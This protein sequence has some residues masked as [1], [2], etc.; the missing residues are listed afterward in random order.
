MN[1]NSGVTL[2]SL[3][4]TLIVIILLAAIS[5]YFGFDIPNSAVLSDFSTEVSNIKVGV[6]NHRAES[7]VLYDENKDFIKVTIEN[8]PSKFVSFPSE[9]GSIIGYAIDLDKISYGGA[10][11]GFQD[12]KDGKVTFGVDDIYVYD[13]NGIIYY[14]KGFRVGDKTY[15]NDGSFVE[16]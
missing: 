13:K 7:M 9:D 8:A 5:F 1:N 6:A 12:V 2:M 15:Y 3:I 10:K 16:N 11:R 4:I 14:A